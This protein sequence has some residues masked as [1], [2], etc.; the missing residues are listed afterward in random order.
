[1]TISNPVRPDDIYQATSLLDVRE[2]MEGITP[3]AMK[4]LSE[5][6]GETPVSIAAERTRT[7]DLKRFL[8][9]IAWLQKRRM[10]EL[11]SPSQAVVVR[12]STALQNLLNKCANIIGAQAMRSIFFESQKE[13]ASTY[14]W[15]A[16]V[17]IEDAIDV[18]IRSSLTSSTVKGSIDPDYLADGF[19][20]LM[21]F[22][23]RRVSEYTGA[24]VVNHIVKVAKDETNDQFPSTAY[25]IEWEAL[26]T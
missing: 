10:V 21:Q 9:D 12:N 3:D 23:T 17:T 22:I 26:V 15:L 20:V 18:D 19:R 8:E 11:V 5:L 2:V 24:D 25:Q 1:V 14:P 6:D 13:L 7:S 4:A 16:F